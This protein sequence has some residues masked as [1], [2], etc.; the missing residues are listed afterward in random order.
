MG[1]EGRHRLR[2]TGR[3]ARTPFLPGSVKRTWRK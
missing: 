2:Y 3:G 1:E